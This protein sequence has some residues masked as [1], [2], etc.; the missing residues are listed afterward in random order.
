MQGSTVVITGAS[1]G[2]GK[3]TAIG[4]AALGARTVLACRDRAR[5]E[6]AAAEI[7]AA[8]G[9]GAGPVELVDLDLADLL[10]VRDCA[11]TL[12]GRCERIDVLVN[13][14][15]GVWTPRRQTRQ[16]LEMTFGV[17]H[18]GH[19]ALTLLLA[20]R[21]RASG[22]SRVVTVASMAHWFAFGG[23]RFGDLQSERRYRGFDAYARSKLANILFTRELARRL[24]GTGVTANA[25]HPG[26]VR[27]GFGMDGD[28]A[29][30]A[31]LANRLVRPFEISAQAGARTSVHVASAPELAAATGGYFARGRPART[32][33]WAGDDRAAARLWEESLRIA[34]GAGLAVPDLV[35]R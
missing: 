31:G 21:L 15:G 9:G 4:L 28:L 13:N 29:G 8:A 34:A 26:P 30:L 20:D 17:N 16:G 19:F 12:L 24:V 18:L 14:A 10:S 3:H 6:A 22:P 32:A 11:A 7:R 27:S 33:P 5:A 23:M 25:V 2:I 1:S 35:A